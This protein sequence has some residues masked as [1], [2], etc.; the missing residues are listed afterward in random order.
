MDMASETL[1]RYSVGGETYA[2]GLLINET[3]GVLGNATLFNV[4]VTCDRPIV[5]VAYVLE[6]TGQVCERAGPGTASFYL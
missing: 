3:R 5:V 1:R 6:P 2:Q 4:K